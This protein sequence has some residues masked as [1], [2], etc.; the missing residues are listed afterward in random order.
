MFCNYEQQIL[1][2]RA[3][4]LV[5]AYARPFIFVCF[6]IFILYIFRFFRSSKAIEIGLFRFH[7]FAQETQ[8]YKKK[9]KEY[10]LFFFLIVTSEAASLC[11][12]MRTVMESDRVT[13]RDGLL[14]LEDNSTCPIETWRQS[15]A[16][17]IAADEK[18]M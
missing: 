3:E 9:K 2:I 1:D 18:W 15:V 7:Y 13:V 11:H 17:L 12:L 14:L 8:K 10:S 16:N 5:Y 4:K 6:L